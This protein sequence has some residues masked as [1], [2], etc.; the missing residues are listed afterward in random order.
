[1]ET[2]KEKN[3]IEIYNLHKSKNNFSQEERETLISFEG[4]SSHVKNDKGLAG[5]SEKRKLN[6]Q[7]FFTPLKVVELIYDLLEIS[8]DATVFDNSCGIGRFFWFHKNQSNC[9]GIEI[10]ENA[11]DICKKIFPE[12]NVEKASFLDIKTK[13]MFSYCLG[14][15]PFSMELF[16]DN[17]LIHDVGFENRVTSHIAAIELMIKAMHPDGIC[18]LVLPTTAFAES[19]QSYSKLK[20][21]MD[22]MDTYVFAKI[23]LPPNS[24]A[25]T[26]WPT[27]VFFLST[28]RYYN[29]R[30]KDWVEFFLNSLTDEEIENIKD[31][32]KN[33]ESLQ[34]Y[35]NMAKDNNSYSCYESSSDNKA[36][37]K[38]FDNLTLKFLEKKKQVK[39][40]SKRN[41]LLKKNPKGNSVTIHIKNGKR[42]HIIPNGI[43][44]DIKIKMAIASMKKTRQER[45]ISH[46]DKKL[47]QERM[48]ISSNYI[49]RLNE[50]LEKGDI[51]HNLLIRS[52]MLLGV[53]II[54]PSHTQ[55]T[56]DNILK[57]HKKALCPFSQ[58]SE[59][60]PFSEKWFLFYKDN[61]VFSRY[62]KQ[63]KQ[64]FDNLA[65]ISER[66]LWIKES[67]NYQLED[68]SRIA[69]KG[70]CFLCYKQGLG[71]TRTSI[72]IALLKG[73][74]RILIVV[75]SR[76]INE[77]KKELKNIGLEKETTIIDPK[78]A[79][80]DGKIK[81]TRFNLIPS[82]QKGIKYKY[83]TP[84]GKEKFFTKK[85]N[86]LFTYVIVDE[87]H[88]YS[89]TQSLQTSALRMLKP[90]QW[91]FLTGT[92]INN[93]VKNL[94][95]LFEIMYG[96][97][98]P[99]FDY[100]P[101]EF[102]QKFVTVKKTS[103]EFDQTLSKGWTTIQLP[104][105][106]RQ[107]LDE[108]RTL[109]Q[110]KWIRRTERDPLV[111][112]D[113]SIPRPKVVIENITPCQEHVKLYSSHMEEFSKIFSSQENEFSLNEE[114]SDVEVL[115]MLDNLQFVSTIPQAEKIN[116]MSKK[117]IL[118]TK[119]QLRV[120]EII[121][122]HHKNEKILVISSRPDFSEFM[123]NL[124]LKNNIKAETF[125]GRQQIDKRNKTLDKFR[126]KKELNV[127]FASIG[128]IETGLNIPEAGIIVTADIPWKWTQ[129]EQAWHRALRPQ[130]KKP[131][132]IHILLNKAMI[133]YY[134]WQH[135]SH[136]RAANATG[137]DLAKHKKTE[138]S[139]WKSMCFEHLKD[140]GLIK[141]T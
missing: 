52:L 24:F 4:L 106:K 61:C 104:E 70:S 54:I 105:I 5:L 113:I 51:K 28:R 133:D 41:T 42:L 116:S 67:Y 66:Y 29:G 118:I 86:K 7:Q 57:K 91:L 137:V 47:A 101:T 94:F 14:N 59:K 33:N 82:S 127:I 20:S 130:T 102:R 90:K 112:Q 121:K 6:F 48:S 72:M 21:W 141:N 22:D 123:K 65:K 9:Y 125:T 99:L 19:D 10:E 97:T 31:S 75:P 140:M 126:E 45:A 15:P 92:P 114:Y 88:D 84:G 103:K 38:A 63:I 69:V 39:I 74:K 120:M 8:E 93:T 87:A 32:W 128:V 98:S 46:R 58:W 64:N 62:E 49:R 96:R 34:A 138:W 55:K 111:R 43:I 26:K 100:T 17:G 110:G 132:V 77:W 117:G 37:N 12:S 73:F 109:T 50:A 30:T 60:E 11:Y 13:K 89:N 27:S 40:I 136:K 16:D 36:D 139:H 83:K 115:A 44:A 119:K 81:T 35:V 25:N 76:L 108:F 79:E 78:K 18:A 85:I 134:K 56:F 122:E 2:L 135:C 129:L 3:N 68:A 107:N 80:K 95:S 1:M 124:C 53:E 71:K 23:T 131:P